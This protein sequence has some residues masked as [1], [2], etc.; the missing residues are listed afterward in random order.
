M[1]TM[2]VTEG[3]N[4]V[5][6][7]GGMQNSRGWVRNLMVLGQDDANVGKKPEKK[8]IGGVSES[9][10]RRCWSVREDG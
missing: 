5:H 6:A 10:Q 1:L 3:N 9:V 8:L 7:A 4:A 2:T